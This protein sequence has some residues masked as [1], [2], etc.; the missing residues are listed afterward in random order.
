MS[1]NKYGGGPSLVGAGSVKSR[2]SG[3]E[4][5]RL[6]AGR[7]SVNGNTTSNRLRTQ[8]HGYGEIQPATPP[9]AVEV[10]LS[11]TSHGVAT[12]LLLYSIGLGSVLMRELQ[13]IEHYRYQDWPVVSYWVAFIP[14]W[15]GDVL[16][17][18]YIARIIS[19]ISGVTV[20]GPDSKSDYGSGGMVQGGQ[21]EFFL[22]DGRF[23]KRLD[24]IYLPLVKRLMF[25]SAAMLPFMITQITTHLLLC[26]YLEYKSL[27]IPFFSITPFGCVVPIIIVEV[28][29]LLHSVLIRSEGSLS[30]ATWLLLLTA[31]ICVS[32]KASNYFMLGYLEWKY[33]LLPIW[34]LD[35]IYFV[36]ILYIPYRYQLSTRQYVSLAC[37][38][39]ALVC[40]TLGELLFTVETPLLLITLSETDRLR[41]AV[42]LIWLGITL[43]FVA[44]VLTVYSACKKLKRTLGYDDPV[45]LS[46]TKQGWEPVGEAAIYY[47]L[48]GEM[49]PAQKSIRHGPHNGRVGDDLES[50]ISSKNSFTHDSDAAVSMHRTDSGQYDDVYDQLE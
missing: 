4:S 10:C 11:L 37:Y 46:K 49:Q 16:A 24:C 19:T 43:M 23:D 50:N 33:V 36:T 25:G 30:F 28:V 9:N 6:V 34:A 47:F 39:L 13:E 38:T 7:A 14:V 35:F 18:I 1:S 20:R 3:S 2:D 17:C 12:V 48:L 22:Q 5:S 42:F 21:G 27:G 41:L 26:T 8:H 32:A 29:A 31:T 40:T 45:I 44:F 15:L